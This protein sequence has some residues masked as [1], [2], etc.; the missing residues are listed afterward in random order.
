M[1]HILT[2]YQGLRVAILVNDMGEI[3]IDAALVQQTAVSVHQR[4]EHL[5]EL[6]NGCICCTLREDLL[7]EVTK[8]ANE[9]IFDHLLIESSGISEPMP[10]AETFTFEDDSGT[11]LGD[12]ATIDAMVTVVDGSRFLLELDTIESLKERNWHADPEDQRTISHLL[13]DQIEFADI[14]VLNKCDLIEPSQRDSIKQLIHEMN[15]LSRI[16]ESTYS[17]VPLDDVLGTGLFSMS[18]AEKHEGWLKEARIGE[19]TPETEEYG[20]SSF[21][22]RAFR[23]FHPVR[24]AQALDSL[25][26]QSAPFSK[27]LRAK[28][29]LWLGHA[30][31]LQGDFSFAGQHYAILPGNPWWAEIDKADWPPGLEENIAPLW[32]EPYGDRQQELVIIGQELQKDA[33]RQA[34][35]DCLCTEEECKLP[36]E[37]WGS[38]TELEAR[39]DGFLD[40]W[41]AAADMRVVKSSGVDHHSHDH[42]H[43]GNCVQ[44]ESD[45]HNHSHGHGHDHHHASR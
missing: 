33:I 45:H 5:V 11:K 34:L 25:Q 16:M 15:P 3:N 14:I 37:A 42:D 41:I 7:T 40:L 30:P 24:L 9:G 31:Q 38:R 22:Y 27:V 21:T 36:V 29:F 1:S 18:E 8:I 20:I 12:I 23:P 44:E 6:S 26:A 13:C 39:K 32:H 2:N 17:A 35:D 19:H 43:H 4:E 28:G 10:V